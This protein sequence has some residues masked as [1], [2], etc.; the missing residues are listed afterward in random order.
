MSQRNN[1]VMS[2]PAPA[3]DRPDWQRPAAQGNRLDHR[4]GRKS[5][6]ARNRA[7]NR[8]GDL[9]PKRTGLLSKSKQA[10]IQPR[11]GP[12]KFDPRRPDYV[13]CGQP[14][15]P[16]I[17][18]TGTAPQMTGIRYTA[19]ISHFHASPAIVGAAPTPRMVVDPGKRLRQRQRRT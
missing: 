2:Q 14:R 18:G 3:S 6:P 9:S 13:G 15:K 5:V 7:G 1:L 8:Q 4:S 12:S 10:I 16:V 11:D 19:N 17:T